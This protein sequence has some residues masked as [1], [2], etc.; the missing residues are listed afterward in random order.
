M[1]NPQRRDARD[2]GRMSPHPAVVERLGRLSPDQL[3]AATAPPGPV[4]C[5][6]PAGS[7]KTTTLVAR[8][9]WRIDGGTRA[10][11][12][13]PSH[14]LGRGVL[15]E[16]GEPVDRLLDRAALLAELAGHPLPAASLRRL[17]DPLSRL[18]LA[19]GV[20]AGALRRRL[21]RRGPGPRPGPAAAGAAARGAGTRRLPGGRRR[22]DD[23]RLAAR[24]RAADPRPC[25][26]AAR[27][28]SRGPARQSSLPGS[29]GGQGGPPPPAQP[30]TLS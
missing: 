6:A 2:N 16:A 23:L 9:A 20:V 14:A 11:R 17:D 26:G 4:L 30:R 22:P 7:G 5:V 18:Q 15:V 24:R 28:A 25:G 10:A 8:V 29:R 13:R 12:G 27:P 1:R 21:R 19:A 3:A